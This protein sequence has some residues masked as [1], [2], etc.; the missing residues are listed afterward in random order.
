MLADGGQR[1]QK[2]VARLASQ[3]TLTAEPL[4]LLL[5]GRNLLDSGGAAAALAGV[6]YGRGGG[7]GQ[8][9]PVNDDRRFSV[10]LPV[11]IWPGPAML[12]LF[13]GAA[14]AAPIFWLRKEEYEVESPHPS[15]PST[16]IVVTSHAPPLLRRM[17]DAIVDCRSSSP[18]LGGAALD[19]IADYRR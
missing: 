5:I 8:G 12:L 7:G 11:D 16:F 2:A 19:T 1:R 10:S 9:F 15:T 6:A 13:L 3:A 17:L 14:D 18:R 4:S